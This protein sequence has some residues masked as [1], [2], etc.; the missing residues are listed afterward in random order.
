[1]VCE[2]KHVEVVTALAMR[3]NVELP[4]DFKRNFYWKLM[5]E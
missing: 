1:M 4:K 3:G 5:T 2:Q